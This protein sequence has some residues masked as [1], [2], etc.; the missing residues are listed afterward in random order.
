[1]L[2]AR[3]WNASH[4]RFQSPKDGNRAMKS[5][6]RLDLSAFGARLGSDEM[7][8]D[9]K[10]DAK[11]RDAERDRYGGMQK[12]TEEFV[13]SGECHGIVPSCGRAYLEWSTDQIR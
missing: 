4:A 3:Q 9:I 1:L 8:G 7:F 6:H 2:F 13:E 11:S 12:A 5:A 10:G